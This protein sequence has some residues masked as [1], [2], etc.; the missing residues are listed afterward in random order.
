MLMF[1]N[2]CF[3]WEPFTKIIEDSKDSE[4]LT[5]EKDCLTSFI[6]VEPS[7]ERDTGK[8]IT[9]AIKNI[10]WLSGKFKTRRVVLHYFSHL[11]I[12]RA[13]PALARD[14][15][16]SMERRLSNA[17]YEVS[18]TPYGYSCRWGMEVAGESLGRVFVDI[19]PQE[20][21]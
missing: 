8:V 20:S 12:D 2:L 5:E 3:W 10:K 19:R 6:H 9:K 14:I 18:T 17:G 1:Y 7:D 21:K 4:G 13:A 16:C 11:S 15:V